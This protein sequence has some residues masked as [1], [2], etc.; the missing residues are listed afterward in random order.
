MPHDPHLARRAAPTGA[1]PEKEVL[2]YRLVAAL[3]SVAVL[4][5]GLVY[6]AVLPEPGDPWIA[7]FLVSAACLVVVGLS[8]GPR[9][10]WLLRGMYAL[11]AIITGWV[12]WLLLLN[13]FAP[14]YGLGLVVICAIICTLFRSTRAL[15]IY[16]ALTLAGVAAV[17][18]RVP[19][20]RVSPLLFGSYLV[21]IL[22]LFLVVVRNRLYRVQGKFEVSPTFGLMPVTWLTEHYNFNVGANLVELYGSYAYTGKRY[23]D[24]FK[25]SRPIEAGGEVLVET[26]TLSRQFSPD[27]V[28]AF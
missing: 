28:V 26:F 21:V 8:F 20:P 9:Q 5:F 18:A 17:A 3:A 14:E 27:E 19:A 12:A 16:G 10:P 22:V 1:V 13:D 11:F 15:A 7:R 2:T 4:A 25:S 24:F 6:R 23:V